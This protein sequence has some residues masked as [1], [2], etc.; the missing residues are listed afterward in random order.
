MEG[1]KTLARNSLIHWVNWYKISGIRP[2]FTYS[3]KALN[4]NG[5]LTDT[6][7]AS[8]KDPKRPYAA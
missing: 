8:T 6:L 2:G 5:C 4:F 7:P 1:K 3:S